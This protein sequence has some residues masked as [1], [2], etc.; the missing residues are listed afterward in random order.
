M[1]SSKVFDKRQAG[2]RKDFRTSDIIFILRTLIQKYKKSKKKW[3]YPVTK[4]TDL[5]LLRSN[6]VFL[7]KTLEVDDVVA[8]LFQ[9]GVISQKQRE[10][11]QG[12]TPRREKCIAL[13][14][15]LMRKEEADYI[16]QFL[17]ALDDQKNVRDRLRQSKNT[18][19][20]ISQKQREEIQGKTPRREKCIALLDVLMRKEEADYIE[21]F[22]CALDDQKNV[23]DRLRQS[24]NTE[25]QRLLDHT[26]METSEENESRDEDESMVEDEA[27]D[28]H[29]ARNEDESMVE[30]E[31]KD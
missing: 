23:R 25:K 15:V 6:Y 19:G 13:L 16:E 3:M 8:Y 12:K 1:E 14:D 18:E 5:G 24:K 30:D 22:L 7:L 31:A 27:K 4:E 2:F 11:I 9:E 10:E 20:V 17:C 21:Q 29:E 28:E 26:D